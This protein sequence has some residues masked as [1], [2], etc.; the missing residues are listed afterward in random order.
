MTLSRTCSVSLLVV[1]LMSSGMTGVPQVAAQGSAQTLV[2]A[3]QKAGQGEWADVQALA[4]A[5]LARNPSKDDQAE[6]H[7]LLGLAWF[8]LQ[9][10]DRAE[11]DF[12]AYLKLDLDGRLDPALVAPEAVTFFESVRARHAGEL[13]ALRPRPQRSWALTLLPPLGQLQ[14]QERDKAIAFGSA[15]LVFT[16]TNVTSYLV[17]RSWCGTSSQFCDESGVDHTATAKK[18]RIVNYLSG[19]AALGTYIYGVVDGVRGY[20]RR[21]SALQFA[22]TTDE[23]STGFVVAGQF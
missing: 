19:V 18:L 20:R 4:S 23:S 17:L 5:V 9:A 10:F 12:V 16:A 8:F 14:N 22:F 11:V 21:S 3:N 2:Q 7:R 15:L 13:R 1:T 6:A